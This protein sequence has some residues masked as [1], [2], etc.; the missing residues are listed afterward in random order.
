MKRTL[1][2]VAAMTIAGCNDDSRRSNTFSTLPQA[3]EPVEAPPAEIPEATH[4]EAT[5][6]VYEDYVTVQSLSELQEESPAAIE[7]VEI[8]T[9]DWQLLAHGYQHDLRRVTPSLNG[10][11]GFNAD[12]GVITSV[13]G[14][15]GCNYFSGR[16]EQVNDALLV[17]RVTTTLKACP[18]FDG[19]WIGG[20][21][22]ESQQLLLD[23]HE[24]QY[25]F[26]KQ[27]IGDIANYRVDRGILILT[28]SQSAMLVF[29]PKATR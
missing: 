6:K 15:D 27:V 16:A 21:P 14:Y 9:A 25:D 1:I 19:V 17:S 29:A 20:E 18:F 5:P 7:N 8:H 24:E 28:D 12:D 22:D 11:I 26:F 23:I 13:Q 3:N 4:T 2:L 10:G